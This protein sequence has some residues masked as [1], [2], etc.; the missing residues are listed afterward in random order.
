[1]PD[2]YGSIGNLITTAMQDQGLTADVEK[3]RERGRSMFAPSP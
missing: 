2:L 3:L 1:L